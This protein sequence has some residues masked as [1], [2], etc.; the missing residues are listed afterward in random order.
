MSILT[1]LMYSYVVLFIYLVSLRITKQLLN[2]EFATSLCSYFLAHVWNSMV[3]YLYRDS[4]DTT[5]CITIRVRYYQ[6]KIPSRYV[7]VCYDSIV[8]S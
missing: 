6:I 7:S 3:L 4:K 2:F 8:K 5:I 1:K